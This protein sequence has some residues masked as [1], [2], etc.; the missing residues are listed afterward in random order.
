MTEDVRDWLRVKF[1]LLFVGGG[2]HVFDVAVLNLKEHFVHVPVEVL[3]Y[4]VEELVRGWLLRDSVFLGRAWL[5]CLVENSFI[6]FL[7]GASELRM[8]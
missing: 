4:L 6:V 2:P 5:R 3:F 7:S 8:I 1:E